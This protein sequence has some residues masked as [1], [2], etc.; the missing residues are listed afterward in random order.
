MVKRKQAPIGGRS[1]R[2]YTG[3]QY[4]WKDSA[5]ESDFPELAEGTRKVK[6]AKTL[7]A[8]KRLDDSA[9]QRIV[10]LHYEWLKGGKGYGESPYDAIRTEFGVCAST[11]RRIVKHAI[12]TGSVTPKK[13][14]GRPP[15]IENKVWADMVIFIRA[16]RQL[17]KCPS[18][19]DIRAHLIQLGY[20]N[21][22]SATTIRVKQRVM[23]Y[24]TLKVKVKPKLNSKI[25]ADRFAFAKRYMKCSFK[26]IVVVDEKW[27]TQQKSQLK[28]KAKDDS[29]LRPTEQF[30]GRQ[31]ETRTQLVKKMYLTCVTGDT[32]IANY[33][34]DI[35][36]TKKLN[37]TMMAD[38]IKMLASDVKKKTKR[39]AKEFYLW[40]DRASIHTSKAAMAAT[41]K[42]FKGLI[43]QPG[44]SP[45]MNMLDSGVF[46]LMERKVDSLGA[47]DAD[48]I[49]DAVAEVWDGI[50]S[51]SLQ[52]VATRVRRNM[53]TVMELKGG[54]FYHE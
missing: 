49:Q 10:E 23:G 27:F 15:E 32:K 46:P 35:H 47:T 16:Q 39:P 43:L 36:G 7:R 29:P 52:G 19:A 41:K 11:V 50:S 4:Q 31:A 51:E 54:N 28:M 3:Q 37:A 6:R 20:D 45:D 53:K 18:A 24:K 21:P 25:K 9:R 30:V 33:P 48:E 22:P 12:H 42:F 40:M 34:L 8:K 13:P 44:K 2:T 26:N 38:Q 14:P 1:N 17:H 5:P